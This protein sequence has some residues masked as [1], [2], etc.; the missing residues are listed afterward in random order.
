MAMGRQPWRQGLWGGTAQPVVGVRQFVRESRLRQLHG[1]LGLWRSRLDQM[2]SQLD[3]LDRRVTG[4]LGSESDVPYSSTDATGDPTT[5]T[6]DS[7]TPVV[8]TSPPDDDDSDDGKPITNRA[9]DAA[10]EELEGDKD[11]QTE[12]GYPFTK[13]VNDHL[14]AKGYQ[15][16]TKKQIHDRYDHWAHLEDEEKSEHHHDDDD[17]DDH[18]KGKTATDSVLFSV[19]ETMAGRKSNF[20]KDGLPLV[21]KVNDH[22]EDEGYKSVDEDK[23]H[24]AYKKFQVEEAK[25]GEGKKATHRVLFAIF[26]DIEGQSRYFTKDG[27]HPLVDVV[28]DRLEKKGYSPIELDDLKKVYED[29]AEHEED[30][31]GHD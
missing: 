28:N 13:S 6:D 1:A 9:L 7:T 29:F 3:A 5:G 30:E 4:E 11:A 2:R 12:D 21:K 16:A 18:K 24:K 31:H 20:T 27:K 14:R 17:D 23:V 26:E 10:F 8:T 22:L 19:F 15:S 25:E